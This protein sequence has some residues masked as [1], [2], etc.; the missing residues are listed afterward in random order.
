MLPSKLDCCGDPHSSSVLPLPPPPP[1]ASLC[2]GKQD[3]KPLAGSR[4]QSH[5]QSQSQSQS[6]QDVYQ[7]IIKA[8]SSIANSI[9]RATLSR[10]T[11]RAAFSDSAIC[12]NCERRHTQTHARSVVRVFVATPFFWSIACDFYG[13]HRS[14]RS[15]AGRPWDVI[16]AI[17]RTLRS[18]L[19]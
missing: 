5:F 14:C 19:D 16:V 6:R 18:R 15:C 10:S 12:I 9:P 8:K 7:Q 3:A 2:H 4:Y 1:A 13:S 11:P 17:E